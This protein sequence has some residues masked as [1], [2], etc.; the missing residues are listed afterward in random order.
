MDTQRFIIAGTEFDAND[1][2]LQDALA[3]AYDAP[4]RPRCL[5]TQGGVEMYVARHRQFVLKRMPGSGMRHDP[6]CPSY[7]IGRAHV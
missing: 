7:E 4:D 3:R 1:P 2:R 5:C 6:G